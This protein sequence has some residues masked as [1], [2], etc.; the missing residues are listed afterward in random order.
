M[1]RVK[2]VAS[3]PNPLF[4]QWLE[5]FR[6]EAVRKENIAL[7]RLYTQCLTSLGNLT[8]FRASTVLRSQN[9][10]FVVLS[11]PDRSKKR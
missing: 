11:V 6:A 2:R 1:K 10:I 4:R 3:D 5:E 8:V 9:R 7:V